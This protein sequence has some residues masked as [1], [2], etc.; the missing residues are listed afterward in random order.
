MCIFIANAGEIA[1]KQL[2]ER[3]SDH[4][5]RLS[6]RRFDQGLT[7]RKSDD[8]VDLATSKCLLFGLQ[9]RLLW[10]QSLML[11]QSGCKLLE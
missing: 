3:R 10:K 7:K 4:L 9:E 1:I 8:S 11:Q 5:L 2:A 6:K